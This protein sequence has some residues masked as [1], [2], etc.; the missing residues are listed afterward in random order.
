MHVRLSE[1]SDIYSSERTK[2][3]KNI[4]FSE[5]SIGCMN[6]H[7]INKKINKDINKEINK[8]INKEIDKEIDKEINKEG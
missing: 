2:N 4:H 7:K 1:Q 8:K 6:K 3:K 5:V